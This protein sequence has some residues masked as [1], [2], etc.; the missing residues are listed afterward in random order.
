MLL[1]GELDFPAVRDY[2]G[3]AT[4]I[5]DDNHVVGQRR[6]AVKETL[7]KVAEVERQP[8]VVKRL[9]DRGKATE[10]PRRL[11]AATSFPDVHFT[12]R[13]QAN[14]KFLPLQFQHGHERLLRDLH[15]PR[16]RFI[17]FLP[18]FCFSSS[19]RLRVMSPP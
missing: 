14:R 13:Q 12:K 19:L 9:Q 18:S 11:R 6:S 7:E 3:K 4:V 1:L 8:W 17:R 15:L 10:I 16:P 5:Y 2:L